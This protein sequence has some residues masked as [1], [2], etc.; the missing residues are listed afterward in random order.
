MSSRP[1]DLNF[2]LFFNL[3]DV[4][5]N[6]LNGSWSRELDLDIDLYNLLPNPD[7]FDE[8]DC[9]AMLSTPFSQYYSIDKMNRVLEKASK[10]SLTFLHCNVRSLSKNFTLLHDLLY[11]FSTKPEILAVTE[12]KLNEINFQHQ[13]SLL[14]LFSY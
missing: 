12:T 13:P 8:N 9:D 2:L 1:N 11:S 5:F 3:N 10:K 6:A 4:E 7:K 14:Q